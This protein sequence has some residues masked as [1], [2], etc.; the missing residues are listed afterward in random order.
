MS[1]SDILVANKVFRVVM[2]SNIK[3]KVTLSKERL[4]MI[5]AKLKEDENEKAFVH[6][7]CA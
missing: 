3:I 7:D 1:N 2:D 5:K 4:K 6:K